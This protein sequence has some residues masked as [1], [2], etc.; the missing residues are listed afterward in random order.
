[1]R[2][3]LKIATRLFVIALAYALVAPLHAAMLDEI[4]LLIPDPTGGDHFGTSVAISGGVAVVG[5]PGHGVPASGCGSA[6]VFSLAGGLPD[7]KLTSVDAADGDK[8]GTSVGVSG[9]VAIV[10]AY[11]NDGEADNAGAAYLFDVTTGLELHKLTADDAAAGDSFGC[12]VGIDGGVAIVGAYGKDVAETNEGAAYLFNVADGSQR[13]KL[14]ADDAAATACFGY[15]VAVSGDVALVGAFR[16]AE[17]G[18]NAGAA[19]LFDATTG[20]QLYKLTADDNDTQPSDFFG[21][22]VA[23]SGNVAIVGAYGNDGAATDAGA[24]YLFDVATG[25]E[26]HKLTAEDAA[27]GDYFGYSVAISGDFALVGAYKDDDVGDKSGAAYLFNVL[28]GEQMDKL[29]ASDTAG[30]D[31]L[32]FSVAISGDRGVAGARRHDLSAT[33]AGSAYLFEATPEPATLTLLALGGLGVL[34]RRKRRA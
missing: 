30:G 29:V 28:T 27:A 34:A 11:W 15:S 12:S 16:D 20:G 10:G 2:T 18:S 25:L 32:G 26:L 17:L 1:M 7:H 14:T 33:D 23:I 9:D 13:C 5:A 19:Y 6:Y 22:S 3:H 21:C 8:F 31:E 4:R 24:A